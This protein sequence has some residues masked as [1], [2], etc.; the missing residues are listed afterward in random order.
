MP[1]VNNRMRINKEINTLTN[2]FISNSNNNSNYNNI[3]Q[4][5]QKG[6]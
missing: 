2:I 6:S 1:N 5:V 4:H 3:I